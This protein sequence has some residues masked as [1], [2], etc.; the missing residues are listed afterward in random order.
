MCGAT[1]SEHSTECERRQFDKYVEGMKRSQ[2]KYLER[3]Q[4]R[5]S[6]RIAAGDTSAMVELAQAHLWGPFPD[7]A[8]ESM[9]YHPKGIALLTQAA[10]GG[11]AEA[12]SHLARFYTE[13]KCGLPRDMA[14]AVMWYE[15][16]GNWGGLASAAWGLFWGDYVARTGCDVD[17]AVLAWR[18]ASEMGAVE[19]VGELGWCYQN[20]IGVDR[21]VERAISLYKRAIELDET[22]YTHNSWRLGA[23]YLRGDGV[24]KDWAKAVELMLR[25]DRD[26]SARAYLAWCYLC[27]G[28]GVERNV[29]KALAAAEGIGTGRVLA[30]LGYCHERGVGGE[31]DANKAREMYGYA[32]CDHHC[33]EALGELGL[34]FWR[35]DCGV[36]TD[37]KSAVGYFRMGADGGDPI[38]MYHFGVCLREGGDGVECDMEQSCH[39]LQKAAQFGHRGA[40]AALVCEKTAAEEL[41]C[42]ITLTVQINMKV[43]DTV[44]N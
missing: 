26:D 15:R 13:G 17:R 40:A 32:R 42:A 14:M 44:L 3:E 21:D 5:L 10:E 34:Y 38:S 27:G 39:W 18:N 33:A 6:R 24:E 20:G 25:C 4:R 29:G 7:S 23:C 35:G 30:F 43:V 19:A 16:A 36:P 22:C 28:Y 8:P 9:A 2:K 37:K 11:N 31:V 1:T 12:M 41:G